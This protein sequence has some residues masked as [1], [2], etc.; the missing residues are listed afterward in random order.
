M[1]RAE[2]AGVRN[3]VRIETCGH[4]MCQC[5]PLLDDSP[6]EALV[7]PEVTI[8]EDKI[9]TELRIE[10]GQHEKTIAVDGVQRPD[11]IVEAFNGCEAPEITAKGI[12]CGAIYRLERK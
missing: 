6:A 8:E 11:D 9:Y 3:F 2:Y 4:F 10:S 12:I 1:A 7:I 5:K